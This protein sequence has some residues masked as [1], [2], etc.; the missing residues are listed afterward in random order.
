MRT[1]RTHRVELPDEPARSTNL[2]CQCPSCYGRGT[3]GRLYPDLDGWR[4]AHCGLCDGTGITDATWCHSCGARLDP[5]EASLVIVC[6]SGREL[7]YCDACADASL[8]HDRSREG[9]AHAH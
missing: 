9:V 8:V 2:Y 4:E 5:A 1:Y 3:T 6:A 7:P